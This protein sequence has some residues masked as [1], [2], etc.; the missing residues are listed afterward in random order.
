MISDN[1][2]TNYTTKT[3]ACHNGQ[4]GDH[5]DLHEIHDN[6]FRDTIATVDKNGKR[7]WLYPRKPGGRFFRLRIWVSLILIGMLFSGPFISING[8]PLLMINVF[9]RE[10]VILG[11]VFFPQDFIMLAVGLLTFF[12]FIM[13]FT[14]VF[15]RLWC[16]WACPQ[17]LFMEMVFRPVEY[18][19]EG[20]APAQK[21]LDARPADLDK[22]LRKSAKHALFIAFSLSVAHLVMAYI[23]GWQKAI[24][25]IS[26]G[27]A[28]Q[29]AAFTA[30]MAFSLVFWF[31]FARARE[32][33]CVAICPYGRLQSVLLVKDSIVVIY[34]YLRGEPRGKLKKGKNG[35]AGNGNTGSGGGPGVSSGSP[36]S[37]VLSKFP[38]SGTC[39]GCKSGDDNSRNQF[40]KEGIANSGFSTSGLRIEESADKLN[41]GYAGSVRPI[42][43]ETAVL[44]Q[45]QPGNRNQGWKANLQFKKTASGNKSQPT[46]YEHPEITG[47]YPVFERLRVAPEFR[48]MLRD[49]T[50]I[51]GCIKPV[52]V[53]RYVKEM[54]GLQQIAEIGPDI[55]P[56]EA[57]PVEVSVFSISAAKGLNIQTSGTIEKQF[58]NSTYDLKPQI[59]DCIDCGICVSVCPTGIDIR[60]GTQ[61]ECI[62]C[63]ACIDACDTVM[64]KI[65]RPRGLIRL[66]SEARVAGAKTR[67][68]NM[69]TIAYS[70]VLSLLVLLEAGMI[71]M[72]SPVEATVL[73]VPGM[74]Y[75]V[76]AAGNITNLYNARLVNK[77]NGDLYLQPRLK[78]MKGKITLI[79]SLPVLKKGAVADLT[80]FVEIQPGELKGNRNRLEIEFANESNVPAHASTNFMGPIN[81]GNGK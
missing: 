81:A 48:Q 63:T 18:L 30:L 34:D 4:Q 2:S 79:G 14:S 3:P 62:N 72:R 31:V 47:A 68:F 57:K 36:A 19:L 5:D 66:D 39:A 42:I 13:M 23:M 77:T 38:C 70:V 78:N 26:S 10:F 75:Q 54:P 28:A 11:N 76:T 71:A 45:P 24:S 44:S 60:N 41:C 20:D 56:G 73:R 32:Q 25:L 12:V 15:G 59:G 67:R 74:M 50:T 46:V 80:F 52:S 43:T 8:L 17:T 27:P 6:E 29:P 1:N 22:V 16:G 40:V 53:N 21:R 61:L 64:D 33:V 49:T 35:N 9:E 58:A 65:G 69:R 51:T 7:V 37:P 55:L